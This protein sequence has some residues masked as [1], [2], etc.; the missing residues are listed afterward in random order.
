MVL[1]KTVFRVPSV[2]EI[3]ADDGE[4]ELWNGTP[5]EAD[6]QF[7]VAGGPWPARHCCWR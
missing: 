4:F 1:T 2:Q 3:L 7:K 6:V 5:A